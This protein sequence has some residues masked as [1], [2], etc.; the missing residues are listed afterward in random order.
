MW[1]NSVHWLAATPG[2]CIDLTG[3]QIQG[4]VEFKNPYS[5][6]GLSVS[7]AIT[8]KNVIVEKTTMAE[9]N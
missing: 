6:R 7:N 3:Y 8:S 5:Y 2:G 9:S 1:A 4:L